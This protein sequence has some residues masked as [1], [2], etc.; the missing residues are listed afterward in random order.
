MWGKYAEF[1]VLVGKTLDDVIVN[2]SGDDFIEFHCTDGTSYKM[3]HYND[4][5]ES[6][7]I[8]DICGDLSWLVGKEIVMAEEVS[9]VDGVDPEKP[10]NPDWP[11]ESF[12]WTFYKIGSDTDTITIRWYGSSNGYYSEGVSFVEL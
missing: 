11:D 6:V 1:G 5:C 8:E 7:N 12:T 10:I 9:S 3:L 2:R 4:C